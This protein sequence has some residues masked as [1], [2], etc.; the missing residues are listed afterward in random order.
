M[1]QQNQRQ[2][3]AWYLQVLW[4]LGARFITTG[5]LWWW[6]R[7]V[8]V[9][10]VLH[11]LAPNIFP[12]NLNKNNASGRHADA[13]RQCEH[14]HTH[15]HT[16][17]EIEERPKGYPSSSFS[18]QSHPSLLC[19]SLNLASH[20]TISGLRSPPPP[21]LKPL[22]C[23]LPPPIPIQPHTGTK[24]SWLWF[25]SPTK[26]LSAP[27]WN[28]TIHEYRLECPSWGKEMR[29]EIENNRVYDAVRSC[30]RCFIDSNSLCGLFPYNSLHACALWPEYMPV[31]SN[32]LYSC[33]PKSQPH[34]LS[35]LYNLCSGRHSL[36]LDPRF[37]WGKTC[38][39]E[40]EKNTFNRGTKTWKKPHG[41]SQPPRM[42]R[43][44]IVYKLHSENGW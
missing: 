36:S 12:N 21:N 34:C 2:I 37:R 41:K 35:G 7:L 15:T 19:S 16:S 26:L 1:Q 17:L 11:W 24:L 9:P 14:I 20:T 8:G 25:K 29:R 10:A 3:Q 42:D 23:Y 22:L 5:A 44:G 4:V 40:K 32:H 13:H 18:P 43:R 27:I 38:Y 6:G 39:T 28:K 31:K 33:S 30:G